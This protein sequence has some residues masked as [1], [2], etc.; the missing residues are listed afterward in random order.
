MSDQ[1]RRLTPGEASAGMRLA[2]DVLDPRGQLLLARGTVLEERTLG[3]L[4]QRAIG[5]PTV[6]IEDAEEPSE[7]ARQERLQ[8]RLLHLF[9]RCGDDCAGR[10]LL[11]FAAQYRKD[12]KR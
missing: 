9:R 10:A 3:L 2:E 6:A 7:E 8:R 11:Q 4:R 5:T 12:A 1:R